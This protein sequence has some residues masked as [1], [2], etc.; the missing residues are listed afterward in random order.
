MHSENCLGIDLTL[1]APSPEIVYCIPDDS[2][3]GN[4]NG[5][6]D[7]GEAINLSVKV[8]NRGSSPSAGVLNLTELNNMF[9]E[10]T[11]SINVGILAPAMETNVTVPVVISSDAI[12][13]TRIPFNI[14]LVCSKYLAS[15]NYSLRIGRTRETWEKNNFSIF[16]WI[17]SPTYPW[18]ITSSSSYENVLSARSA[19]IPHSSESILAITVNNPEKDTLSFHAKVSSEDPFDELI[20]RIDSIQKMAVSGE[21]GWFEK[22]IV[23]SPGIHYL[24]WVYKKDQSI[25]SGL[26][27]AWIDFIDFPDFSFIESDIKADTVYS[28]AGSKDYSHHVI[29]GEIVNLGRKTLNS[30]PL[31][32]KI[33][34]EEPVNETFY[35]RLNPG[36]TT[37]VSFSKTYDFSVSGT[38]NISIIS[39]LP[40]DG[41][42]LND[43]A[44]ISF[45]KLGP[46]A[47]KRWVTVSPNPFAAPP[48]V[49]FNT[50]ESGIAIAEITD[51]SGRL[52]QKEKISV[53]RGENEISVDFSHIANGVYILRIVQ[54]SEAA[55]TRIVKTGFIN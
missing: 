50:P 14:D 4:G 30:Y 55:K 16:P 34:D 3:T 18:I 54:G 41:F 47:D 26:D 2:S 32:Y 49:V 8:L 37:I 17:V 33:N 24:E 52:V 51:I 27:A 19:S 39:N 31:A 9:D 10:G 43:T 45:I 25:S 5:I 11:K 6:T 42:L 1:H 22:S 29:K 28:P 23:L 12:S 38:Y 21:T 53:L 15:E 48:K 44:K 35:T 36:D 40:G 20:L 46:E 13:G 7:P